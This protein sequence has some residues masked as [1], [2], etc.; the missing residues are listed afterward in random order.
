MLFLS[1]ALLLI[2]EYGWE[3]SLPLGA[4]YFVFVLERGFF[5][6]FFFFSSLLTRQSEAQGKGVIL[7]RG[8]C[9]CPAEGS[10]WGKQSLFSLPLYTYVAQMDGL[11]P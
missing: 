9:V 2:H 3:S 5:L 8:N 7:F 11:S 10:S 6:P 1:F 4:S